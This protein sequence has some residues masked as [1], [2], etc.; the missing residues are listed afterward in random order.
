MKF[1]TT[2]FSPQTHTLSLVDDPW[3]DIVDA[4]EHLDVV[5]TSVTHHD[6]ALKVDSLSCPWA[7]YEEPRD[8]N[9]NLDSVFP[10]DVQYF[11]H[12]LDG[13]Q[14]E[15][16]IEKI[17]NFNQ[18]IVVPKN[19]ATA[20]LTA[21]DQR[22]D[23]LLIKPSTPSEGPQQRDLLAALTCVSSA[24]VFNGERLEVLGDSFL[25]FSTSVFLVKNHPE[26]HEGFLTTCKGRMV[27]NRNLFYLGQ[28]LVGGKLKVLAFDPKS[29]WM[30]P[31]M[32]VPKELKVCREFMSYKYILPA[33][34]L[35]FPSGAS[36][37]T[38]NPTA[39][40][41]QTGRLRTG[42][43]VRSHDHGIHRGVLSA[44]PR[45]SSVRQTAERHT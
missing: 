19:P 32:C 7:D 33:S 10:L 28:H 26:W 24:D 40:P 2:I 23:L 11:N 15:I 14:S 8:L 16:N 29:S 36:H 34:S 22:I 43:P 21:D 27:S 17:M 1:T 3:S 30:P 4:F 20:N 42:N 12:F 9:R 44:I 35:V 39:V 31:L 13:Y 18:S 6:Q 37:R 38:K 45:T 41:Y 5:D 25:K